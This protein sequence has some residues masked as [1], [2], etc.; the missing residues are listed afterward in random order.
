M[1]VSLG[2]VFFPLALVACQSGPAEPKFV[3][4]EAAPA[5][6]PGGDIKEFVV[7]SW[8]YRDMSTGEEYDQIYTFKADGTFVLRRGESK[9]E[10]AWQPSGEQLYL[11]HETLNGKTFQQASEEI[12]K[13]AEVGSQAGVKADVFHDWLMNDLAARAAAQLTEDRK[14]FGFS[15]SRG[16]EPAPDSGEFGGL[17]QAISGTLTRVKQAAD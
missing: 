12:R 17:M 6:A 2:M 8:G 5:L 10:G 15:A 3:D 16:T 14:T 7:G 13:Q 4:D 11:K 9:I 1:R